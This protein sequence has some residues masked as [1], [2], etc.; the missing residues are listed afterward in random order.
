MKLIPLRSDNPK[1]KSADVF[2]LVIEQSPQKALTLADMRLRVKI[3]DKI[4]AADKAFLLEDTEHKALGDALA[5]F[6]WAVFDRSLL[7][8][9]EDVDG[10]KEH[11]VA[12]VAG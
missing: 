6:P 8:I 5:S 12:V 3:L 10:A 11:L 2:K 1:F 9:L 7:Q 4:E